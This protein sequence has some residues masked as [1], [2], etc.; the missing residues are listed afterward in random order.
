[1]EF[2]KILDKVRPP[3]QTIVDDARSRIARREQ[4]ERSRM[5]RVEHDPETGEPLLWYTITVSS[6]AGH[7]AVP[8]PWQG[9]SEENARESFIAWL[10]AGE[11]KT[12]DFV[13][14]GKNF[15]LTFRG[16]WVSGFWMDGKGHARP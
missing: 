14:D 7:T 16:S 8:I 12:V 9:T 5:T 13:N 4:Q 1:M 11:F 3:Q 6:L 15:R 2:W 10:D